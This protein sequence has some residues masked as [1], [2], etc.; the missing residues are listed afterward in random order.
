MTEKP[1]QK[2]PIVHRVHVA[3]KAQRDMF[4]VDYALCGARPVGDRF[5]MERDLRGARERV[6]FVS[7]QRT[8][9]RF[10]VCDRCEKKAT[11]SSE[12]AS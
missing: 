4:G 6:D 8:E 7:A 2:R 5:M 3:A 10:A 11:P 12:V 1:E 9:S